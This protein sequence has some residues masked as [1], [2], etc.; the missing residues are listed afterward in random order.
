MSSNGDYERE[1]QARVILGESEKQIADSFAEAA[2][3]L[4]RAGDQSPVV[5]TPFGF[6]VILLIERLPAPRY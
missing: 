5:R 2:N 4:A 3:A 1:R 6:H